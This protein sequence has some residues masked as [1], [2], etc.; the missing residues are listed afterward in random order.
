MAGQEASKDPSIVSDAIGELCNMVAGNCKAKVPSLPDHCMLSV[1]TVITGENYALQ[2]AEPSE[3]LLVV[4]PF[5][6]S[7]IQISLITQS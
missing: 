4:F 1:S 7:P 5:E 6:S 2:S 3:S